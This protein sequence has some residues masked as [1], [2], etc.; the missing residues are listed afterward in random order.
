MGDEPIIREPDQSAW[1]SGM[2]SLFVP[3]LGQLTQRRYGTAL[4]QFCSVCAYVIG[5]LR[6][7][8]S[9]SIGSVLFNLWL[10]I[11]ALWWARVSGEDS[12]PDARESAATSSD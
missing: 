5:A 9:C 8:H 10:L 11:N 3:G 7:A 4:L 6:P 1:D 2:A 12:P